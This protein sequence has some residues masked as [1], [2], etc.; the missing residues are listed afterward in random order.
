[1]PNP[2][3]FLFALP[4]GA[5][6]LAGVL[7]LRLFT[8]CNSPWELVPTLAATPKPTVGT[9]SEAVRAIQSGPSS[10]EAAEQEYVATPPR[11]QALPLPADD[12]AWLQEWLDLLTLSGQRLG[13]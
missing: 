7:A 13:C 11:V 12:K 2:R 6:A 4:T 5:I 1:M 10:D 8:A 3:S 9:S